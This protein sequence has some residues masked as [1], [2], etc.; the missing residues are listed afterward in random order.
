MQLHKLILMVLFVALLS[1]CGVP[2]TGTN[3]PAANQVAPAKLGN[4]EISGVWARP[5]LAGEAATGGHGSGGHGGGDMKMDGSLSA[6]YM[7][8]NN[9]G[10]A[11]KLIAAKGDV[12]QNIELHTMEMKDGVMEM[13]MVEGGID[14]PANGSVE[15]KPGGLHV[16]LIGLNRDLKNG[17][18][19]K[20]TLE[21]EKAGSVE[22]QAEVRAAN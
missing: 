15:L 16:M 13:R 14:I 6:A 9:S 7:T 1:A 22:V 10:E 17:D 2:S 18:Q 21:F 3:S 4:L 8:I 19:V 20:L 5:A 11:D 12:A